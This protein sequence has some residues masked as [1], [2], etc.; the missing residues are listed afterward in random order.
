MIYLAGD[1]SLDEVEDAFPGADVALRSDVLT[2]L[3]DDALLAATVQIVWIAT[4]TAALLAAAATVLGLLVT[5]RECSYSLSVLR[6]LGLTPPAGGA[7]LALEVVPSV[8]TAAAVGAAAGLGVVSL[9]SS[10][11]D[12]ALLST[13]VEAGHSVGLNVPGAALAAA[14]GVVAVVLALVTITIIASRRARLG[15]VLRVG[16]SS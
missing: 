15:A 9:S 16:E 12:F 13:D 6:T 4:V 1:I 7:L 10:S 3:E 8:V 14:G 5:A 2:D 11:V